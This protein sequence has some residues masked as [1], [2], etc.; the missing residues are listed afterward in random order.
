MFRRKLV[1]QLQ[2]RLRE[3]RRFMQVVIG[4]RQT[5]KT[6]GVLQALESIARPYHYV[7]ADDPVVVSVEWLRN[8]WELAQKIREELTALN[9]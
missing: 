4:P 8:E 3:K 2:E 6:T 9:S 7:S 1:E 5:G